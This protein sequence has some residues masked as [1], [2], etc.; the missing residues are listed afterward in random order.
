M[1]NEMTKCNIQTELHRF[2]SLKTHTHNANRLTGILHSRMHSCTHTHTHTHQDWWLCGFCT[3]WK[4]EVSSLFSETELA[5]KTVG[6]VTF[7][8]YATA[9]FDSRL[10]IELTYL[11]QVMNISL[12]NRAINYHASFSLF[13]EQPADTA[14]IINKCS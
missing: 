6:Q 9:C 8:K 1:C 4:V 12:D 2:E 5:L 11:L 7:C 3:A 13:Y 14:H 10:T